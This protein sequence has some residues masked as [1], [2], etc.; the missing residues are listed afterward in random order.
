MELSTVSC[1][2]M[3]I[4]RV[5]HAQTEIWYNNAFWNIFP[6]VKKY[7]FKYFILFVY[8]FKCWFALQHT[9]LDL[10]APFSCT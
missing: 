5:T 4:I 2:L 3:F 9:C 6:K 7:N 1:P 10:H 8:I